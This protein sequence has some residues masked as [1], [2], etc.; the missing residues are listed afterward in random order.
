MDRRLVLILA[1]LLVSGIAL[2]VAAYL[3]GIF[4]FDL[5][6]ARWVRG[7]D[8]PVFIAAIGAVS[9]FGNGWVPIVLV[10]GMA[11]FCAVREKWLEAVFVILTLSAYPLDGVLKVLVGRPRPPGAGIILSNVLLPV[12]SYAYPSG[13]V[14]FYVVFFG[15]LAYLSGKFLTGRV[16]WIS[17]SACMALIVLIGPSRIFL[18]EHWVSDVLGSYIIGAFWLIV[19]ILLYQMLLQRRTRRSFP[20]T[21]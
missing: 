13:H 12:N 21:G 14:L 4:P 9:F 7:F 6:V 17:V 2:T 19:L 11:A 1:L 16:R 20:T 18:G 8:H 3:F 15:F 5:Q 10:F